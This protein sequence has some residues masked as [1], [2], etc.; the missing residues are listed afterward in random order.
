MDDCVFCKIVVGEVPAHVVYEDGAHLAF[1][2]INPRSPGHIQVIP[3]KH[4]RFVWD[5]PE[6]EFGVYMAAVQKLAK[7]LQKTFGTDMVFSRV[8]GDE[9]PHAHVWLFPDPRKAGGEKNDLEA[10]A[11][12]IRDALV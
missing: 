4:Y 1:L 5:V 11:Q 10:N 6:K 7:A 8:M 9:V 12:R 2:D 3:K